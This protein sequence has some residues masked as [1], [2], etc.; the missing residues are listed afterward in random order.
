MITPMLFSKLS[1]AP[2]FEF[3]YH[4]Y[5]QGN[6]KKNENAYIINDNI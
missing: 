1:W 4:C 6:E 3:G 2:K 5:F